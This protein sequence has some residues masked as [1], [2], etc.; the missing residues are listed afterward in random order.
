MST[1]YNGTIYEEL[2][3]DVSQQNEFPPC[4]VKQ[5]DAYTRGY[6]ITLTNN[7]E[8]LTIPTTNTIVWFNCRNQT[9]P[10]KRASAAGTINEDGTVTVIVPT[11]VMEVAGLIQCDISIITASG[12]D[13]NILKSTLFYLN[14]EEAANPDGTTTAAEDSILAGIAAGTIG[15]PAGPYVPKTRKIAGIDLQ[16]DITTQELKTALDVDISGKVDKTQKIAGIAL[17]GDISADDLVDNIHSKI[18][19]ANVVS[20]QTNGYLGQYGSTADK[21]PMF[22]IG[23]SDWAELA[24]A[25]DIP[26]VSG[27]ADKATTLMGYGI[28][29][30]MQLSR[31]YSSEADET[32]IKP[33]QVWIAMGKLHI[34]TAA[35]GYLG[36]I[37]LANDSD[38]PEMINDLLDGATAMRR[39]TG[40]S[41][42]PTGDVVASQMVAIP[43]I[44]YY[45]G[46]AW[47]IYD[48]EPGATAGYYRYKMIQLATGEDISGKMDLAPDVTPSDVGNLASGQL[49]LVTGGVAIK[50]N[51]GYI[52]LERTSKKVTSIDASSSNSEY[53]S[54]KA[55]KDYVDAAIAAALQQIGQ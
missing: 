11:V 48:K 50:T 21:K 10:T 51:S 29:D 19:P 7:G 20:G 27:K 41:A 24:K 14:C 54:A 42:P 38:V 22:Y 53:P 17:S 49:F 15:P 16:D 8:P 47:L 34:K 55:V 37:E 35:L 40:S 44:W 9:D 1:T 31:I 6:I 23:M 4:L 52:E 5:G 13:T 39:Y 18:N 12:N 36:N 30:G 25:S 26:D 3:V 43:C 33:G 2:A 32:Q 28:T 45:D 46:D